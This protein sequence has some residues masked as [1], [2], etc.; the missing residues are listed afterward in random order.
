MK[1]LSAFIAARI[2]GKLA[3]TRFRKIV[4]WLDD[5]FF[6]PGRLKPKDWWNDK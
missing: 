4:K 2:F 3:G 1:N 5:K 6:S